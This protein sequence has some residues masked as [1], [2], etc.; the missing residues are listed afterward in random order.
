MKTPT[1]PL[2][3]ALRQ[4]ASDIKSPDGVANAAIAEAADRLEEM[5]ENLEILRS[6]LAQAQQT[7]GFLSHHLR[8]RLADDALMNL[9]KQAD[10]FKVILKVTK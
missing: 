5:Q 9:A 6:A 3:A 8:G 10:A 7:V 2:V 4:L 1:Q